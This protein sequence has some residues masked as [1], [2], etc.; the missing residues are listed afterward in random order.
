MPDSYD[1][2]TITI[3]YYWQAAATSGDVIFCLS[4]GSDAE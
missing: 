2:G 1:D 3:T 4:Q